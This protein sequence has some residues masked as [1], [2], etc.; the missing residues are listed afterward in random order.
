MSV[1]LKKVYTASSALPYQKPIFEYRS[2]LDLNNSIMVL[3]TL[4]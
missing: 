1:G 3:E 4:S 2:S